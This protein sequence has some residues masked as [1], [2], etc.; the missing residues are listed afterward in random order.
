MHPLT[1]RLLPEHRACTPFRSGRPLGVSAT[2]P[3]PSK[4]SAATQLQCGGDGEALEEEAARRPLSL[5]AATATAR[6][7]MHRLEADRDEPKQS[8]PFALQVHV[9]VSL[10]RVEV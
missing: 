2:R 6:N 8:K 4:R 10:S 7:E 9:P 3:Q 1:Q 5:I